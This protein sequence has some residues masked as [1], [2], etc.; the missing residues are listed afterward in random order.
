MSGT[1]RL[2]ELEEGERRR[3]GEREGGGPELATAG[4]TRQGGSTVLYFTALYCTVL[5]CTVV[6]RCEVLQRNIW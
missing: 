3:A 2:G 1:F 6:L 4:V 5:Y